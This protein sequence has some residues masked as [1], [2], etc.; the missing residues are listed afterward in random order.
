MSIYQPL[1]ETNPLYGDTM[2]ACRDDYGYPD[3]PIMTALWL[4]GTVTTAELGREVLRS[5]EEDIADGV[6]PWDVYD[7]SEL[8]NYVDAN[9]YTLEVAGYDGSGAGDELAGAVQ[10]WVARALRGD[11]PSSLEFSDEWHEGRR[12]NH[13]NWTPEA[14]LAHVAAENNEEETL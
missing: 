11:R 2:R 3:G 5:I 13:R 4:A 12:R 9:C 14:W 7:F 8:H 10:D 1:A 6:M